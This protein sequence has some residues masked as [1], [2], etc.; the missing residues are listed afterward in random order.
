MTFIKEDVLSLGQMVGRTLSEMIRLLGASGN[1][2]IIEEQEELINQSCKDIEEKCLDVLVQK[3]SLSP[4]EIRAVVGSI[5]IAAKF[6][7]I[8]DHANRVAKIASWA[9]QDAIEIPPELTEMAQVVE[10]MTQ[11]VLLSFLSDDALKAHEIVQKDSRV[12]YLDDALSKRLLSDLGEQERA[13]AQMRA[14]FLFCARFLERM[15]D[16][17]TSVAKRVYF[18]STGKRLQVAE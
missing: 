1:L 8:A 13:Q 4:Q 6:E 2:E 16:A 5:I 18:I 12:D 9:R 17:C 7:R 11:D 10:R 3:E 15:G 14:Q